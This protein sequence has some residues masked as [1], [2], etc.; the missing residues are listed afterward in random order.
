M[1][2]HVCA[3]TRLSPDTFMPIHVCA[4]TC[5]CP[6]TFV[7]RK[8]CALTCYNR[9]ATIIS[10]YVS[11]LV[12][13]PIKLTH[14][15]VNTIIILLLSKDMI[16]SGHNNSCWG[17]NVSGHKHVW[18]QSCLGTNVCGHSLVGTIM[19]GHKRGGTLF[20]HSVAHPNL[21]SV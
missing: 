11:Y 13:S 12:W 16:V 10:D 9:V 21:Q 8:I 17:I 1:L 6:H 18:A 2:R 14:N 19:Y 20:C 15:L 5:L 3:Q 7:P 4:Q